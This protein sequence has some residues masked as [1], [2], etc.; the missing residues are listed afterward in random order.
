MTSRSLALAA[1]ML[2]AVAT[3][4]GAAKYIITYEGTIVSGH[5]DTGVFGSTGNLAG[6]AFSV[7]FTLIAPLPGAYTENTDGYALIA[8]GEGQ[9]FGVP[10]PV[11]AILQIGAVSYAIN[12]NRIGFARQQNQ[13]DYDRL[14][15]NSHE[16]TIDDSNDFYKQAYIY[17][18]IFSVYNNIVL[19][20]DYTNSLNYDVMQNDF[21]DGQFRIDE[22]SHGSKTAFARGDLRPSRVTIAPALVALPVPEPTTWALLITGFAAVGGALRLSRRKRRELRAP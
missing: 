5:D 8:G 20:T 10:S 11:S 9:S 17:A 22:I 2:L 7:V 14:S 16:L 3:P 19:T 13:P 6:R 15:H 18:D 1:S 12:G 21:S 4:A